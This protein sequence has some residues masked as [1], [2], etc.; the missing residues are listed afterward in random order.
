MQTICRCKQTALTGSVCAWVSAP[1]AFGSHAAAAATASKRI[2]GNGTAPFTYN[3]R[4]RRKEI[5]SLSVV[6][7]G[8]MCAACMRTGSTHGMALCTDRIDVRTALFRYALA[9]LKDALCTDGQEGWIT[10]MQSGGTF[11]YYSKIN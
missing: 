4:T 7:C 1:T 10:A 3:Y 9:C 8:N 11:D 6:V 2:A 5:T